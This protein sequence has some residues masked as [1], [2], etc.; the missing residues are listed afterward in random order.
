MGQPRKRGRLYYAN[1]RVGAVRLRDCLNTDNWQEALRRQRELVEKTEAGQ[2]AVVSERN[3][4]WLKYTLAEA[5]DVLIEERR[6][7]SKAERTLQSDRERSKPLKRLIGFHLIRRITA[8]TINDYQTVRKTE[9]VSSRTVNMEVTLIRLILKRANRWT[10][11]ADRVK[12][13]TENRD[14]VG[15]TLTQENKQKLFEVAA[16]REEWYRAL[17]CGVIAVNTTGRKIEVLR[18]RFQDVDFFGRVWSIPRSKTD[19]GVRKI[20]LNDEALHAFAQLKRIVEALGGGSPEHYFFPACERKHFDF[21]KHQKS[22]RTAWRKLTDT[23]GLKGFRIHDLR[24]QCLTEMAEAD[25]PPD[26]MM[27][28]AGHLSEKMR[29]HYVHVRDQAKKK[30]VAALPGTGLYRR[31]EGKLVSTKH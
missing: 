12:N 1:T 26:V 8:D 25:I 22:V 24:H 5:L 7:D 6:R 21:T 3:R 4:E 29:R 10:R 28:L 20:D 13:L 14:V 11:I 9:R 19:A 15:R 30:A 23:A 18:S 2:I 27:S 16:S 17:Y 31:S